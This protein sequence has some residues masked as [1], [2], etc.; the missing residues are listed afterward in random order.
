MHNHPV[1]PP[2][3]DAPI[4]DRLEYVRT[5]IARTENLRDFWRLLT[6]AQTG[7][8]AFSYAAARTYHVQGR[9]PPASYLARVAEVFGVRLEWLI[10]G[11]GAPTPE[12]EEELRATVRVAGRAFARAV[13]DAL[14]RVF[15]P[16]RRLGPAPRAA[17]WDLSRRTLASLVA[18]MPEDRGS[19][20]GNEVGRAVGRYLAAPFD[21][22]RQDAEALDDVRLEVVV[23][24]LVQAARLA[25]GPPRLPQGML[26]TLLP[27]TGSQ[28]EEDGQARR[29]RAAGTRGE[30]EERR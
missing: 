5:A 9:E 18:A 2:P 15:P 13:E 20:S 3:P 23:E 16:Y 4:R 1:P 26:D 10:R 17:I 30:E 7:R 22:L 25:G 12:T 19:V 6:A 24:T 28:D 8:P 29:R 27:G 21:T 11:E 14:I